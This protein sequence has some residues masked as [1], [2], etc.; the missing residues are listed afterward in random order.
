MS[1]ERLNGLALISIQ[2][3]MLKEIDYNKLINNFASY[4]T[5]I[6]SGDYHSLI[7][8]SLLVDLRC[9]TLVTVQ[10]K[11]PFSILIRNAKNT[12]K[13]GQKG[14]FLDPSSPRLASGSPGHQIASWWRN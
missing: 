3:E 9:W 2:K 7:F 5:L 10:S 13:E 4:H 14:F 6:S 12:K 11:E 8:W 1:Q